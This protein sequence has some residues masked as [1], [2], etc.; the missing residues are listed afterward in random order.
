MKNLGNREFAPA[1][2]TALV[3]GELPSTLPLEGWQA[4]T[5][6]CQVDAIGPSELH[7]DLVKVELSLPPAAAMAP[8]S[9]CRA[10]QG[11]GL[12]PDPEDLSG[13][14]KPVLCPE[15]TACTATNVHALMGLA[16]CALPAGHYNS[17]Q[18]PAPP[19]DEPFSADPGGWHQTAPD[20][21]GVRLCWADSAAGSTPH[22][23]PILPASPMTEQ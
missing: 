21:E 5:L 11:R 22:G 9:R 13:R 12:V 1:E 17:E 19:A 18:R 6:H 2:L 10:C 7:P 23:S 15:C 16:R 8:P 3:G 4:L 14:P 20:R